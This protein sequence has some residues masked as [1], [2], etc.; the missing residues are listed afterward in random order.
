M[1]CNSFHSLHYLLI[2]E[3]EIQKELDIDC[4]SDSMQTKGNAIPGS[5][6]LVFFLPLTS[7]S[8]DAKKRKARKLLTL[9][10]V[11][12]MGGISAP[13]ALL[14]DRIT[15]CARKEVNSS[16]TSQQ[17][18]TVPNP[19][20]QKWREK[21]VSEEQCFLGLWLYC[22]SWD[23]SCRWNSHFSLSKARVWSCDW[24]IK[25]P[26]C[27]SLAIRTPAEEPHVTL[28]SVEALPE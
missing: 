8:P 15:Y 21:C 9:H 20:R 10:L 6:D 27:H 22:V 12:G 28:E 14:L 13:S 3:L 16:N 23:C 18:I 19:R 7:I 11:K 5:F 26:G 25:R 4:N 1:N 24:A 2:K 17:R